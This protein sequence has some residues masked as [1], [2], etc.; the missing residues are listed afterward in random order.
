MKK[1]Y[2]EPEF[3]VLELSV[4]DLLLASLDLENEVDINGDGLWD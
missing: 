3:E 1:T 4:E 2:L